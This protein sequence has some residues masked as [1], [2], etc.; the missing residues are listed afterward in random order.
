[1]AND[2]KPE[3]K[4]R[5]VPIVEEDFATLLGKF[6]IKPEVATN[7]SNNIS[8]IGGQTVFENPELLT[9]KLAS[10]ST[11]VS[12]AKRKLIIEQWFAERG[13]EVPGEVIEKAGKGPDQ[14]KKEAKGK[15]EAE[16]IYYVEPDTAI[17]R[18]AAGNER[19]TT[20]TDAKELQKLIKKDLEEG[21]K[22]QEEARKRQ[23]EEGGGKET[24]F[25]L[26]E[27]GAWTLNPKAR[28]GF[29]EFAV[30]QMYQDSLKKGEPID[31]VEELARREE[32]SV[33]L[34]E[35]MGVKGGEDTEMGILD[36]LEKLGMLKKTEGGG[37]LEMLQVLGELGVIKKTGEEGRTSELD[38][39]A[40][41]GDL[42]FLRKPGEEGRTSELDLI[43]KLSDLGLLQKPGEAEST[44]SQTVHALEMQV[45]EL[46]DEMRKR[47]LDSLKGLVGNL[48]NQVTDL[49][50]H[51]SKESRLEG[52]YA[53]MEKTISTVD[54]QLTGFRSDA[55]PLLESFASGGGREPSKRSPEEKAKIAKGLKEAVVLEK[56]A[57]QL[58]DE[59][60]FGVKEG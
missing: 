12:P 28:I 29:G 8:H 20:L 24:A 41:L 38:L 2:E 7:I 22:R 53:L 40:K 27:K 32:A 19:A 14:L 1:M 34:K 23:E 30:F 58:E 37:T 50:E 26:G 60:L 10:W 59:L 43:S 46:T 52:R 36:K 39:I 6:R 35:A 48:S 56:E 55:R 49:R 25:V 3:E 31:P 17:V 4:T 57:R 16:N 18:L 44:T 15:E 51:M 11:E 47:E 42:G 13:I 21:R 33:R 45:K 9:K 54:N 5:E